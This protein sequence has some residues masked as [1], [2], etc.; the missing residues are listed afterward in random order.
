ML[1]AFGSW[2]QDT[3]ADN[4]SPNRFSKPVRAY[5]P[6][7]TTDTRPISFP[8]WMVKAI[9]LDLEE[10][11]RL[12]LENQLYA[13]EMETYKGW[14]TSLEENE[15]NRRSQ[16]KL[17]EKNAALL[18]EQLRAEQQSEKG[19]GIFIWSLRLLGAL[20]AGFVLGRF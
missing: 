2:S 13:L 4:G 7:E 10:K 17:L 8:F 6:Y 11:S 14:I 12:E 1:T 5:A 15:K 19:A 20:G 18:Q 16:L 3:I 9:A